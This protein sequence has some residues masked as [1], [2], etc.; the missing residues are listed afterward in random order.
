MNTATAQRPWRVL[1]S[2]SWVGILLCQ[3]AVAISSRNIGKSAWWLGP[4]SNPQ[5]PLVWA[6]PFAIT[7]AGLVATQRPRRYTIFIHLG[8]VVAL[9]GVALGD[10]SNAPGVA[11]LEFVLAGIALLVS[12]VSLASRP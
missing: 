8:C 11:L 5:F 3:V 12:L 10:V 6:L 4:E 7:V 9:V 1:A 2:V